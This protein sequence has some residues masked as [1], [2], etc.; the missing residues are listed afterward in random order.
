MKESYYEKLLNVETSKNETRMDNIKMYNR[1]EPTPYKALEELFKHYHITSKDHI[2]DFGSGKGRL[3]FFSNFYYD[4]S[5][6]GI[7]IVE[8]FFNKAIHNLIRYKN[9]SH[10]A[11]ESIFFTHSPAE[12]Y[13][14]SS[15]ENI[16]YFFNPFSSKIF[17][18]VVNNILK[19]VEIN[20]RVV[21]IIL[22][23]PSHEYIYFLENKTAFDKLMEIP[24]PEIISDP[25][26]KFCIYR[27]GEKDCLRYEEYCKYVNIRQCRYEKIRVTSNLINKNSR[28]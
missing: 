27:L 9:K 7:E 25:R 4:V 21:D 3:A 28:K 14:I 17:I 16:F 18:S 6:T 10:K 2:V 13:E 12:R 5:Y 15:F 24:L 8:D 1:Y 19:S 20:E 26:E 23:Y 11:Y 22:Y